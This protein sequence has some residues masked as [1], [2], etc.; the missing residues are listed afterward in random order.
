MRRPWRRWPRPVPR[1]WGSNPIDAESRADY[2]DSMYHAAAVVGLNTSALVEA[3]IVD[4][5]V[6]TMLLPEFR[7]T[8]K[9]PSTSTTC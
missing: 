4:R 7:E 2:F 9:G 3:A 5:P 1:V 6:F 8:R